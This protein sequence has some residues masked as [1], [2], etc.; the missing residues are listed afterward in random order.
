MFNA[1][2]GL[3]AAWGARKREVEMILQ[4]MGGNVEQGLFGP[5]SSYQ[6]YASSELQRWKE[7]VKEA[8]SNHDTIAASTFQLQEVYAS[9]RQS[10][11]AVSKRRVRES[12]NAAL[13]NLPEWPA[14]L[15]ANQQW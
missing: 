9:Y 12:C 14:P 3:S 4:Q 5:A 2:D 1:C 11:D 13:A 15:N 10:G 8:N 7:M 6:G